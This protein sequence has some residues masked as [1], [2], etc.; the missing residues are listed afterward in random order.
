MDDGD[1]EGIVALSIILNTLDVGR[2]LSQNRPWPKLL[3]LHHAEYI[4]AQT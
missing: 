3:P 4:Y 1:G 2:V